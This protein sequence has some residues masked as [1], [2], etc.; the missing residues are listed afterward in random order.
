[1]VHEL[2]AVDGRVLNKTSLAQIIIFFIRVFSNA[3]AR[4]ACMHYLTGM[5]WNHCGR[6]T[7]GFI[8]VLRGPNGEK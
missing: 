2:S 6:Q 1:M 8:C 3:S 7:Q 5:E 4:T